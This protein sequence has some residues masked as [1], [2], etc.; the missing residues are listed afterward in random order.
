MFCRCRPRLRTRYTGSTH[1]KSLLRYRLDK[2][3]AAPPFCVQI[4]VQAL[5]YLD[6]PRRKPVLVRRCMR[7]RVP[8]SLYSSL[9][10]LLP[11]STQR[12]LLPCAH[13][14]TG[15]DNASSRHPTAPSRIAGHVSRPPQ[16]PHGLART[17][18]SA[19]APP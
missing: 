16:T 12:V 3:P 8:L 6:R 17:E 15:R 1:E 19:T 13:C 11:S 5:L 2:Q 14:P 9:Q 18:T 4:P 7:A 10:S